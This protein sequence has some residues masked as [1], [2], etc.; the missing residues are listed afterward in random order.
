MHIFGIEN[1][2]IGHKYGEQC[3]IHYRY[4]RNDS[5]VLQKGTVDRLSNHKSKDVLEEVYNYL[6]KNR[7]T[8]FHSEQILFTT[9]ILEDKLEADQIVNEVIDLIEAHIYVSSS[10][11]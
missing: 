2:V 5:H 7:H 1:I 3:G 11:K 4:K 9:R 8:L 6:K 10:I